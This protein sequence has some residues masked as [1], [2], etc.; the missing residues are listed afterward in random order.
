MSRHLFFTT[1]GDANSFLKKI[2][3]GKVQ[4]KPNTDL[5]IWDSEYASLTEEHESV[6]EEEDGSKFVWSAP[7]IGLTWLFQNRSMPIGR[8]NAT[9]YGGHGDWRVPTL[10][11]LKTLSSNVKNSFGCYA[12]EGLEN[13]IRGNYISCTPY[14]YWQ[15]RAWWNFDEGR[16][17]TERYSEGKIKWDSECNYAGFEEDTCHNFARLILVRG[18]ETQYLSDWAINLRDWAESDNDFDFP[19]TQKNIEE[20]EDLTLFRSSFLHADLARLTKLKRLTCCSDAGIEDVLFSITGLE[21]LDLRRPYHKK[22]CLEEIP[23]SVRNLRTL[24]SLKASQLGLNKVHEAIG[25]LEQLQDLDLSYN[26]IESVP[27]SIGDLSELRFLHLCPNYITVV[28]NSIGQLQQLEKFSIGGHFDHLPESIGNLAQLQEMIIRSDKLVEIPRSFCSLSKLQRLICDAPLKR[29]SNTLDK[30]KNL[31]TLQIE[32]S[33][34]ESIPNEVFSMPWLYTL[35]ITQ[36]PIKRIPDEI[37]GMTSLERL[38]LTGTQITELPRSIL[39]LENLRYLNVSSTQ[40]D[41]LPEWLCDMKSLSDINGK[42]VKFPAMLR[43]KM[44]LRYQVSR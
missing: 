4:R 30:L 44:S 36:T 34:L 2:R 40:I 3:I 25:S 27:N 29:F 37:S 14:H 22:P 8:L 10:R 11:E 9:N 15:D 6:I 26:K 19:V 42:G 18:V 1:F 24:V 33:F 12:K 17:T 5:F 21:K 13:R 38:D 23:A 16:S 28:P 35:S 43:K 32:N 39:L 31:K 41:S 20:L 7:D